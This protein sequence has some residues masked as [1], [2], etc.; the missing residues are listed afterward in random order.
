M[1][2]SSF[3]WHI[4][5]SAT[6]FFLSGGVVFPLALACGII[7]AYLRCLLHVCNE[8]VTC[9]RAQSLTLSTQ[10]TTPRGSKWRMIPRCG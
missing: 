8:W 4:V 3:S 5:I 1:V 7:Q 10:A 6:S 9:C 2:N